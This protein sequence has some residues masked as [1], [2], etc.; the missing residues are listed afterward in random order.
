MLGD[1]SFRRTALRYCLW[2]F[3]AGGLL[4]PSAGAA[5][6]T[7]EVGFA[8][9]DITPTL[10]G[11]RPVWIAG[12]GLERR[13]TKVLDPLYARAL[14]LKDGDQEIALVS[15]DSIGL[16][17]DVTKRVRKRLPELDY[18]MVASTH[19]HSTPD[20]IGLWGPSRRESGKDPAYV[21]LIE[22]KIVAAVTSARS[23]T[24]PATASFGTAQ[25]KS[26]LYDPRPPYVYDDI[27]RTLMF[28]HAKTNQPLAIV[29]QW[30]AH[31]ECTSA[32]SSFLSADYPATLLAELQKE[33]GCPGLFFVGATGGLM[34]PNL[35]PLRERSGSESLTI[36]EGMAEYGKAVTSLARKALAESEPIKLMPMKPVVKRRS[37]PLTNPKFIGALSIG[38]L[39]RPIYLWTGDSSELGRQVPSRQTGS[40]IAIETEAGWLQLGQLRILLI[41]GEIH[42]E[43]VYGGVV[44]PPDLRLDFPD[45]PIE[46]PLAKEMPDRRWMLFGLANDEIG[47]IIPKRQWDSRKPFA[48]TGS[49]NSPPYGEQNSVGQQA[50]SVLRVTTTD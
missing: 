37:L 43:L 16:Q 40:L 2:S 32:R 29:V 1:T 45:A 15:V 8:A 47:Y 25:D 44:D 30:G 17:Y 3:L 35:R 6:E 49:S 14:V 34:M 41:P 7:L 12:N 31:P 42:P 19:S 9:E 50:S 33:Y 4:S 38:L 36:E 46:P 21:R 10:S 28:R 48:Y 23:S 39:E 18:V 26:L 11:D 27:L 22:D 24:N 20:V 5:A 13:A